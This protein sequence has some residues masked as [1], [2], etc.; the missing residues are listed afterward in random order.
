MDEAAQLTVRVEDED[1]DPEEL[2]QLTAHLRHELLD[3][4]V[5]AVA[6]P[7]LGAPPPGSRAVDLVAIGTLI[8]TFAKSELLVAVIAAVRAWLADSQQ[9]SVRVSLDGDVLELTGLSSKEQ[10]RVVAQWLDRHT[11]K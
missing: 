10:H 7:R 3:L 11:K 5:D 8:V 4:D 9:C 6:S 1:T 2:T